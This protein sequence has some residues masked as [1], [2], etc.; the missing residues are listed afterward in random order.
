MLQSANST[1]LTMEKNDFAYQKL[2][3]EEAESAFSSGGIAVTEV[4]MYSLNL[5]PEEVLL[6]HLLRTVS[7]P[8]KEYQIVK[9]KHYDV[10][11]IY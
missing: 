9:I 2:T 6:E 7:D 1:R 5:A 8:T 3:A 4:L 11:I 10:S